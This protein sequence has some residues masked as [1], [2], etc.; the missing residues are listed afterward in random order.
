MAPP[1][2]LHRAKAIKNKVEINVELTAEEW[3]R[4]F[5]KEREG[6][7]KAKAA[8]ERLECEVAKWRMGQFVE[9]KE[10]ATILIKDGAPPDL[11]NPALSASSQASTVLLRAES[12][13]WE[14]EKLKLCQQLDEKVWCVC[15]CVCVCVCV[16]VCCMHV[17]TCVHVCM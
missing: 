8:L 2:P 15:M 3:K 14:T 7:L 16:C 4:R 6:H 5:E 10:R 12:S 1:P 13:D 9:E 11:S 17:F